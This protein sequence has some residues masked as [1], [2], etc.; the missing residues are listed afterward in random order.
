MR[1]TYRVTKTAGEAVIEV[2]VPAERLDL[3]ADAM[4]DKALREHGLRRGQ[5]ASTRL[6]ARSI[7]MPTPFPV[8]LA[9]GGPAHE[10]AVSKMCLAALAAIVGR[11][12]ARSPG[13]DELRASLANSRQLDAGVVGSLMAVPFA[14]PAFEASGFQHDLCVWSAGGALWGWVSLYDCFRFVVRLARAWTDDVALHYRVD[15]VTGRWATA[16]ALPRRP[17]PSI[18]DRP[19]VEDLRRQIA[20]LWERISSRQL[21][22]AIDEAI[23]VSFHEV[24][25]AGGTGEDFHALMMERICAILFRSPWERT[26]GKHELDRWRDLLRAHRGKVTELG[27]PL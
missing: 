24:R 9:V 13:L 22:I 1:P 21:R 26:I 15:P 17:T 16:A 23:V 8:E 7:S 19:D 25:G 10:Q 27:D 20:R 14:P 5:I 6:T 2:I 18:P 12:V 11:E 3:S 4:L